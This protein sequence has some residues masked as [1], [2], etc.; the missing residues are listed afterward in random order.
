MMMRGNIQ[1]PTSNIQHSRQRCGRRSLRGWTS[2]VECW[3]LL[4]SSFIALPLCAQTP[5]EQIPPLAAPYGQ[6]PPTFWEQQRAVMKQHGVLLIVGGFLLAGATAFSLW[7]W[8]RSKVRLAV[9]PE[10]VVRQ[11]LTR[12]LDRP[13]DGNCLDEVSRS[14]RRYFVVAFELGAG[15]FT[16]AEIC[17]ALAGNK[18]GGTELA[19]RVAD[20]L[21]EC[22]RRRFAPAADQPP[23]NAAASALDVVT[24]A[25]TRRAAGPA[26]VLSRT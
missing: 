17:R 4:F 1:H 19:G 8:R 25:E 18:T 5:R 2:N 23:F 26:P 15:E 21:R 6:I 22:D 10:V 12:W 16:T 9:P 13:N 11:A 20:F 14:V 3:A 7:L 24:A